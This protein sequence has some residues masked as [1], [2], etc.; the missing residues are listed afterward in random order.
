MSKEKG[1]PQPLSEEQNLEIAEKVRG[2]KL[3]AKELDA[4][5]YYCAS[6]LPP[7]APSIQEKFFTLFLNGTPLWKIHQL[8][9]AYNLGQIVAASIEGRWEAR[10]QEYTN[11]LITRTQERLLQVHAESIEMLAG[12]VSAANQINQKKLLA[13]FQSG[14]EKDLGDAKLDSLHQYE[15][16]VNIL[17]TLTNG[18]DS[19]NAPGTNIFQV[20]VSGKKDA[21][22]T[23]GPISDGDAA[24][25]L[26]HLLESKNGS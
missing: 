21:Q 5:R 7:L 12:L 6:T 3:S 10:I 4:Y 8:N 18:G 24:A 11:E 14:D 20:N 13:F 15:K 25:F 23:G 16:A 2:L 1:L 22:V 19:K 17:K 9:T 26:R